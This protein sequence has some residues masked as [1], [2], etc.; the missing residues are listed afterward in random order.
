MV[1]AISL[2]PAHDCPEARAL[3]L[4]IAGQESGWSTRFQFG[5]PA[6][7]FWQFESEAIDG[8][9]DHPASRPLVRVFCAEQEIGTML[10]HEAVAW[11]DGLAYACA[12]LLLWT[13]PAPLP[14]VG[15]V[16]GSWQVYTRNWAPG[17]PDRVRWTARYGEAMAALGAAV[18]A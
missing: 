2:F 4:A 12:R 10:M 9:F 14:A 18:L 17:R 15:D 16:E 13:D 6:R 7:G 1:P 5:G 8:V 3:L 11:H